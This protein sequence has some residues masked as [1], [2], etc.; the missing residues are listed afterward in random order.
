MTHILLFR[1][2]HTI[3]PERVKLSSSEIQHAV[4]AALREDIGSGDATSLSTVP[5][6]ATFSVVMRAREPMV[7]AGINFAE[8]AFR[9]LSR[10]VKIKRWARDGQRSEERR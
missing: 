7:L 6:S 1:F 4:R 8:T 3:H 2:A 5:A 9:L 10:T